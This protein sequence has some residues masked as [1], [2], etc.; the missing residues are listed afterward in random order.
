MWSIHP[1]YCDDIVIKNL[2]IRSTGGNGDGIDI[3][4]CK[5]VRIEGC[6]IC[7]GR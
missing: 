3:D 7:D 2:T 6:D 1:T 4:S 5:R